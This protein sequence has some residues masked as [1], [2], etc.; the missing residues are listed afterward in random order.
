M[1]VGARPRWGFRRRHRREASRHPTRT[2]VGPRSRAPR[3]L[4][5]LRPGRC[6]VSRERQAPSAEPTSRDDESRR[7][8][9]SR[10]RR[11]RRRRTATRT[12]GSVPWV[13]RGAGET[14]WRGSAGAPGGAVLA[15]VVGT[16]GGQAGGGRVLSGK[17]D[18]SGE[19]EGV[20]EAGCSRWAVHDVHRDGSSSG[21]GASGAGTGRGRKTCSGVNG[22]GDGHVLL[23]TWPSPCR[24][25][26]RSLPRLPLPS[27]K[28]R[29]LKA[30]EVT[31]GALTS[32][33]AA[34]SSTCR[35]APCSIAA[36][37]TSRRASA[38][39]SRSGSRGRASWDLQSRSNARDLEGDGDGRL[40]RM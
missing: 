16:A 35:C 5:P 25:L 32:S 9:A 11:R 36:S 2:V 19:V 38:G 18:V 33:I 3:L 31:S 17:G 8:R 14:A 28:L 4:G 39:Q 30:S 10:A 13:W 24:L 37:M 12:S 22:E 29:R 6:R 40:D 1:P 26:C 34:T 23:K 21:A 20:S 7:R 27:V 15:G